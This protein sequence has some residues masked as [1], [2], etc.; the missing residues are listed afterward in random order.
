MVAFRLPAFAKLSVKIQR[1][2]TELEK[3]QDYFLKHSREVAEGDWGALSAV[4]L[5][6]HNIYN[7]IEDVLL[8]LA[9]DID[10]YVPS[11]SST[12]QDILDQMSADIE[13]VRPAVL[14]HELYLNLIELKGF[15]HLVRHRYG[16]D[17]D[18]TKVIENF[19]RVKNTYPDFKT[20]IHDLHDYLS[21]GQKQSK[22]NGI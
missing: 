14:D 13:D 3:L 15:R 12:H 22:D 6:I 20:S 21:N 5:G 11:G 17:L 8:N 16:F 7:G 18:Q 4:S 19:E 1:S 9:K 10:N 2:D